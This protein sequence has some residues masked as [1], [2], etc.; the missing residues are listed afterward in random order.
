VGQAVGIVGICL[1]AA[2]SSA[3]LAWRASMQIAG[4]PSAFSAWKNQTD[5]GP[6]SNTTRSTFGA[7]LRINV[8]IAAGSEAHLP[9]QTRLP[10]R[11]IETAVSFNDTSSRYTHPWLFSVRCMGPGC[12]RE[13][14]PSS[15]GEQPPS[16]TPSLVEV[17]RSPR[18]PM[19]IRAVVQGSRSGGLTG[20]EP[21]YPASNVLQLN[22]AFYP[23]RYMRGHHT[24]GVRTTSFR[25]H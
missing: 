6:V 19:F 15:T 3:A 4:T 1:L 12:C 5:S 9:R 20:S 10:A 17:A 22:S 16:S 21:S 13:P 8:A 7:C 14:A 11:R 23:A 2:I 18:Y 25:R 24:A